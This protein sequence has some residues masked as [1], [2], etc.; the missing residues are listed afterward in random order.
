MPSIVTSPLGPTPTSSTASAANR[1]R[2]RRVTS[3]DSPFL[4][5]NRASAYAFARPVSR[6]PGPG[7]GPW[8]TGTISSPA[9]TSAGDSLE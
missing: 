9:F 2:S 1:S 8:K 5:V 3:T 7:F 6:T 4:P